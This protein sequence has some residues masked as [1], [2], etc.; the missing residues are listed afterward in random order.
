MQFSVSIVWIYFPRNVRW[1]KISPFSAIGRDWKSAVAKGLKV[2]ERKSEEK[3]VFA[4]FYRRAWLHRSLSFLSTKV[5]VSLSLSARGMTLLSP[6]SVDRRWDTSLVLLSFLLFAPPRSFSPIERVFLSSFLSKEIARI[7]RTRRHD[8]QRWD[9]SRRWTT[10]EFRKSRGLG[11]SHRAATSREILIMV[12][13]TRIGGVSRLIVER[14][15]PKELHEG[16]TERFFGWS[17]VRI[18]KKRISTRSASDEILRPFYKCSVHMELKISARR[19]SMFCDLSV[20]IFRNPF[21]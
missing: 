9:V 17:R 7:D 19:V 12:K 3:T 10:F 6:I 11:K 16:K 1:R 8:A 14:F 15:Q 5:S 18:T 2:K 21:G 4:D 20:F 13:T